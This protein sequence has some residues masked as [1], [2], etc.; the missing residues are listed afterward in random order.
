MRLVS[1]P[2]LLRANHPRLTLGSVNSPELHEH[3]EHRCEYAILV[4]YRWKWMTE[5]RFEDGE[6]ENFSVREKGRKENCLP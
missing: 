3:P 1:L 2:L 4:F 6:E 5:G